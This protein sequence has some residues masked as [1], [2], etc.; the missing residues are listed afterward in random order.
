MLK[1]KMGTSNRG[2]GPSERGGLSGRSVPGGDR[3]DHNQSRSQ[4]IKTACN[5]Q[6]SFGEKSKSSETGSIR[7]NKIDDTIQDLNDRDRRMAR[8]NCQTP[9]HDSSMP[10]G[11]LLLGL[12]WRKSDTDK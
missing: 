4:V 7:M 10:V 6:F 11:G 2:G 1:K 8:R 9:R 3:S 12:N 5:D